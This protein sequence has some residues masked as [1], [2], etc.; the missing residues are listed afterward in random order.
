[1]PTGRRERKKQE[2][3]ERV[4]DAATDLIAAQGLAQTTIDQIAELADISQT[5]FFNYFPARD[6]LVDALVARLVLL[7]DQVVDDVHG[8]DASAIVKIDTLFRVSAEL[9]QGQHRLM[10]DLIIETVR[11]PVSGP[12]NSLG[13]VR[14]VFA[15]DLA[16]GQARGEIRTDCSAESLA[17]AALG[18][19]SSVFIFWTTDTDY[20]VADRLLH[21]AELATELVARR[22]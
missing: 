11:T 15:E 4:L 14:A 1:V 22:T 17:D 6:D 5:T 9:T 16:V 2:Q 10:R 12:R 19:F 21:A 18:L 8:V 3:R 7:F 13:R 20:P